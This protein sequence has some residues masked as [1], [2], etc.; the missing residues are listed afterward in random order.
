M[1]STLAYWVLRVQR[2]Q[3]L[4]GSYRFRC[5]LCQLSH[6]TSHCRYSTSS[7][8][9]SDGNC[10][11]HQW[12]KDCMLHGETEREWTGSA[13]WY[14]CEVFRIVVEKDFRLSQNCYSCSHLSSTFQYFP[15]R[16]RRSRLLG[17][18]ISQHFQHEKIIQRTDGDFIDIW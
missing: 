11:S 3:S 17:A 8:W 4:C 18:N 15:A 10:K 13:R 12:Q 16:C 5:Y 14:N 6:F 7:K 9:N 2:I 1:V